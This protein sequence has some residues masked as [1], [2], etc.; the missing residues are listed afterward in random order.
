M[1]PLTFTLVAVFSFF[2]AIPPLAVQNVTSGCWGPSSTLG[3]IYGGRQQPGLSWMAL[4]EMRGER[5]FCGATL[6]EKQWLLTAAH[7]MTAKNFTSITADIGIYHRNILHGD[8]SVQQLPPERVEID[9]VVIH[10]DYHSS[11]HAIYND[12][13]LVH[14]QR[15]V[16]ALRETVNYAL[17]HSVNM[18]GGVDNC[19]LLGWGLTETGRGSNYLLCTEASLK[20]MRDCNS[21]RSYNGVLT[22][23][24]ICAGADGNDACSGDSGGPL[25]VEYSQNGVHGWLQIG[26]IS[27][28][29]ENGCAMRGFPGVYT[30]V[31]AFS[32]WIERVIYASLCPHDGFPQNGFTDNYQTWYVEGDYVRYRCLP[33]YSVVGKEVRQC[34]SNGQLE[35][36]KPQCIFASNVTCNDP[37]RPQFGV[38]LG[39]N[40]SAGQVIHFTCMHGYQL[41]GDTAIHCSL[42]GEWSSSPPNCKKI[43]F[44]A[45]L[46]NPKH[47]LIFGNKKYSVGQ[48]A[49]YQCYVGYE[50]RG[51]S[52]RMCLPGGSW[53]GR[54]PRC[55]CKKDSLH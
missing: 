46:A 28:G 48:V 40:F 35:G 19:V 17:P 5:D 51:S 26:I 50:L 41:E 8:N 27:F 12:I 53:S 11:A 49:H 39:S 23:S 32:D 47:G 3:R 36:L 20:P 24:M 25:I 15:P 31:S 37:G 7:C 29:L 42:A 13:A 52:K 16:T 33:G 10:P 44:C 45:P 30:K 2:S 18:T 14:L 6:V 4:L 9:A 1:K 43:L 54:Q 34:S 55:K 38:R 22:D 21:S